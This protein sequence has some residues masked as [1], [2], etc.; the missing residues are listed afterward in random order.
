MS[1][2]AK[3]RTVGRP[4]PLVDGIEKVTGKAL[5]TADLGDRDTLVGQI[6]R[7]SVSH[8]RILRVDT[9]RAKALDG[10]GR[11]SEARAARNKAAV[12]PTHYPTHYSRIRGF[13]EPYEAFEERMSIVAKEIE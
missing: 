9:S 1:E 13:N 12:E 6:L 7:A 11:S 4:V 10:L 2:K 3:I 5:Y 8:G